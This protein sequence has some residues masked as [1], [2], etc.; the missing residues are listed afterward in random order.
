MSQ[1]KMNLD[2]LCVGGSS[3]NC[4][5]SCDQNEPIPNL[6]HEPLP[7]RLN[8]KSWAERASAYDEAKLSIE[9]AN[10][11]EF[12]ILDILSLVEPKLK[13]AVSEITPSAL[14]KGLDLLGVCVYHMPEQKLHSL[15]SSLMTVIITKSMAK[16]GTKSIEC[17]CRFVEVLGAEN[18]VSSIIDFMLGIQ[19]KAKGS[20]LKQIGV[21]FS[22]LR[23]ILLNF[24]P[25]Q[26]NM[27]SC[28]PLAHSFCLSSDRSVREECYGLLVDFYSW[29]RKTP[30]ID[31]I[32]HGDLPGPQVTELNSRFQKVL[33]SDLQPSQKRMFRP[34]NCIG[35]STNGKIAVNINNVKGS[36]VLHNNEALIS[37]DSLIDEV[38]IV[39]KLPPK[40][41]G[42][43]TLEK[44][45]ERKASLQQLCDLLDDNPIITKSRDY[46]EICMVLQRILKQ[47]SN[48]NVV[49]L[50]L[51]ITS[52]LQA[53][54]KKHFAPYMKSLFPLCIQKLKEKHK[55]CFS[56]AA[57]VLGTALLVTSLD[58]L[59]DDL[60]ASAADKNPPVKIAT[61]KFFSQICENNCALL[62][63][64]P[65]ISGCTSLQ[66]NIQKAMGLLCSAAIAHI[67]D[68]NKE[69]RDSAAEFIAHALIITH[70]SAINLT[71]SLKNTTAAKKNIETFLE[72]HLS[73]YNDKG[74]RL[75]VII[76]KSGLST[77][78]TTLTTNSNEN[79][80]NNKLLSN[81]STINQN[82]SDPPLSSR[83]VAPSV[84][85]CSST[86]TNK[87][88][89][90]Q[91]KA[92]TKPPIAPNRGTVR[93]SDSQNAP[94]DPPTSARGRPP[95]PGVAAKSGPSPVRGRGNSTARS[96]SANRDKTAERSNS[97]TRKVGNTSSANKPPSAVA[98]SASTERRLASGNVLQRESSVGSLKSIRGVSSPSNSTSSRSGNTAPR[99]T[100][101]SSNS[102]AIY[103][104]IGVSKGTTTANVNAGTPR[105]NRTR[106]VPSGNRTPNSTNS[107]PANNSK[108]NGLGTRNANSR[109]N[110]FVSNDADD[111]AQL[112]GDLKTD[113]LKAQLT[114]HSQIHLGH[115]KKDE[116]SSN[117]PS[118]TVL[119][120]KS[121]LYR[122]RLTNIL[123]E[124]GL[125]RLHPDKTGI[126]AKVKGKFDA[127][128]SLLAANGANSVNVPSV[129][130]FRLRL[131]DIETYAN[132]ELGLNWEKKLNI[133]AAVSYKNEALASGL[134]KIDQVGQGTNEVNFSSVLARFTD[135]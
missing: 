1:I 105:T 84:S 97:A 114:N 129:E 40:W 132:V 88:L 119:F 86:V 32:L 111:I 100:N 80:G 54:L 30:G 9:N 27:K 110:S 78:P 108:T 36:S 10:N 123:A 133:N 72:K 69:A 93:L 113:L 43:L 130:S 74:Q 45:T 48:L 25:S 83:R 75:D 135:D 64:A 15:L 12:I 117:Q 3:S 121:L 24:G 46:R 59:M 19:K 116:V 79:N 128:M 31:K 2:E 49:Q 47:E 7:N 52:R 5:F 29:L 90:P 41:S 122:T 125:E 44:W 14:D 61:L 87:T 103:G 96:T 51:Q 50:A 13:D 85:S 26:M 63:D 65:F 37:L 38:D 57:N 77:Q 67:E 89:T 34:K 4:D 68:P 28:L 104:G 92:K 66:E 127:D 21:A 107:T 134:N 35:T 91:P 102:T 70:G 115:T 124:H 20:I 76:S 120:N 23:Q 60:I 8:G 112:T 101:N 99:T 98:R 16:G 106:L 22:L 53:S 42:L 17:V 131:R 62:K 18:V 82:A 11:N 55:A 33:E 81:S 71:K 118:E 126:G 39:P 6:E 94:I 95:R 109:A 56:E 73:P 58:H